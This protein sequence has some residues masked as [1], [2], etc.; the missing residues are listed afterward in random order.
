MRKIIS[1]VFARLLIVAML[2]SVFAGNVQAQDVE[3]V[4]FTFVGND[5]PTIANTPTT[6]TVQTSGEFS[7]VEWNFGDG[8]PILQTSKLTVEHT[9]TQSGSYTAFVSLFD[10]YGNLVD[11]RDTFVSV[12]EAPRLNSVINDSPTILNSPTTFKVNASGSYQEIQWNFGDDTP[13]L[14]TS[15]FTV[16]HTYSDTGSYTAQVALLDSD[17]NIADAWETTVIIAEQPTDGEIALFCNSPTQVNTPVNCEIFIPSS[18]TA[19][20]VVWDFGDGSSSTTSDSLQTTHTYTSTGRYLVEATL[21]PDGQ[22][23]STFVDVTLTCQDLYLE[24]NNNRDTATSFTIGSPRSLSFCTPGDEDWFMFNL[25]ADTQYRIETLNLAGGSDTTLELYDAN[26]DLIASDDNGGTGVA[27]LILLQDTLNLHGG[28]YALKVTQADG[29]GTPAYTYDLNIEAWTPYPDL[30][31][32][33]GASVNK[34]TTGSEITYLIHYRNSGRAGIPNANNVTIT[35]I[36]PAGLTYVSAE[37]LSGDFTAERTGQTIEWNIGTL[38]AGANGYL[39]LTAQVDDSANIG[40]VLTNNISIS[41]DEAGDMKPADNTDTADITVAEAEADAVIY[42]SG[43]ESVAQGDTIW[44]YLNYWNAGNTSLENVE[45]T[46]ELP[47]NTTFDGEAYSSPDTTMQRDGNALTWSLDS[48]SPNRNGYISF[49][50]RVADSFT[51][52]LENTAEIG[53]DTTDVEPGNNT[54]SAQTEVYQTSGIEGEISLPT[55]ASLQWANITAYKNVNGQWRYRRG[56]TP[57]ADGTY[58]IADLQDGLYAVRFSGYATLD[59]QQYYFKK[60]HLEGDTLDTATPVIVPQGETVSNIGVSITME[61]PKAEFSRP[62]NGY[63]SI[64]PETGEASLETWADTL[65]TTIVRQACSG[66]SEPDGD[67]TLR[68]VSSMQAAT[69]QPMSPVSGREGFYQATIE[70][71]KMKRGENITFSVLATCNGNPEETTVGKARRL[72]DPSGYITNEVNGNPV[73]DA[74]VTLYKVPGWEARTGPSDVRPQTCESNLSKEPDELWSQPAPEALGEFALP[75]SGEIDPTRNPQITDEEGHYGWDVAAGCW[76]VVVEKDG[77]VS[78][79]SPVVGVPPEVTDL[80]LT[81]MPIQAEFSA[82]SYTVPENVGTATITATLNTAVT[83]PV[84]VTYSSLDDDAATTAN[85]DNDYT[86]VNGQII[87]PAGSTM[88]TFPITITDDTRNEADETI[89]LAL[90]NP[91]SA[92]LGTNNRVMLTIEDDDQESLPGVAFTD[93]AV[94]VN[95]DVGTATLTVTLSNAYTKPVIVT[96]TSMN[97]D[98]VATENATAGSDYEAV[99]NQLVIPAGDTRATF[100]LAI[101]EDTVREVTETVKLALSDPINATLDTPDTMRVVIEDNDEAEKPGVKFSTSVYTVSEAIDTA[102]I[103]ATLSSA[104]E[105]TVTVDYATVSGGSASAENDYTETSGTLTFAADTTTQS[106]TIT[107]NNDS[108]RENNETIEMELSNPTN[109]SLD[110]PQ[111]ATLVI[112]DDDATGLSGVH[113][114]SQDYRIAEDVKTATLTVTLSAISDVPVEVDYATM[115]S[116]TATLDDDYTAVSG[117]LEFETGAITQTIEVAIR[118]D[119]ISEEDETIVLALSNPV[120]ATLD[121]PYTTTLTIVDDEPET[122]EE[123]PDRIELT[124]TP[125]S[126]VTTNDVYTVTATVYAGDNVVPDAAVTFDAEGGGQLSPESATTDA[127]GKVTTA[128]SSSTPATV[129]VRASVGEISKTIEGLKFTTIG[130]QYN[131]ENDFKQDFDDGNLT[132]EIPAGAYDEPLLINI[133]SL[134]NTPPAGVPELSNATN[135]IVRQTFR[136]YSVQM[137]KPDGTDVTNKVTFNKT[138][139]SNGLRVT[140]K[141]NAAASLQAPV[142]VPAAEAHLLSLGN[143]TAGWSIIPGTVGNNSMSVEL[144]NPG[145]TFA[146]LTSERV[147]Y[148]PLI[149]R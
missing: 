89:M 81:L 105:E 58:T 3:Y 101:T 24:P 82:E 104:Y 86:P 8:S 28:Q 66:G 5:S 76:Y 26:G 116:G 50:A 19:E 2:I 130:K 137:T 68:I 146:V 121:I 74:V 55:D 41:S 114:T 109:A 17:G 51:G 64:D 32:S 144:T 70:D 128:L 6:F 127:E 11:E 136:Y 141:F 39:R 14:K 40:D 12:L 10:V 124:A 29:S 13:L 42:K 63:A 73:Q 53:S 142:D 133:I 72:F 33:K 77:Y 31:V 96:Y 75:D 113:F 62:K 85:M 117:T 52:N 123:T 112:A 78:K 38:A 47:A 57:N 87:F 97:D 45:I 148:L 93:K 67:V 140:I 88:Q 7:Y 9:Y 34:A 80:D 83:F 43:F 15:M 46:D 94:M 107:I 138:E 65:E 84:T 132:I 16:T 54:S 108:R 1:S 102:F 100:P 95:E 122:A 69:T 21:Q 131:P 110:T 44:Y 119:Q 56:T 60:F 99:D 106:F 35:D 25:T 143:Y 145:S 23:V 147:V 49:K 135:P 139:A 27:S 59:G 71:R 22:T 118:D 91:L 134:G 79:V 129:T 111:E 4:W 37:S 103:T 149:D 36:L 18:V 20:G 126:P 90:S 125:D 92:T 115:M 61:P 120:S 30:S 48:L 98:D